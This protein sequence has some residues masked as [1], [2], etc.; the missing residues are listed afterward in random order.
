MSAIE[1]HQSPAVVG[2]TEWSL[3]TRQAE[4]LANSDIIPKAYYRKPA[5]VIVAAITGRKY[6]WDVLT[7]MRNGHVIEGTW[8][9]KPEA[10]LGLVRQAGHSV[11]ADIGPEGATVH[12]KRGDTGD[13]M[14]VEF[15]LAD[16]TRAGLAG[17]GSWRTYPQA[18]CM[19]RATA[20]LC[21]MLFSD[22]TA[23]SLSVEEMGATIDADG[24]IVD[25]E[26]LEP[27]SAD[28]QA[29][30]RTA[31]DDAGIAVAA[32]LDKAGFAGKT[33]DEMHEQDRDALPCAFKALRADKDAAAGT[34]TA[35]PGT[36]GESHLPGGALNEGDES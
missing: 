14:T 1:L 5:N 32:V 31:C 6:G 8:S 4:T 20:F 33:L 9:M 24:E 15:T 22:V 26:I 25:A 18:M 19:W 23:G 3:I 2:A 30:I 17:K 34:I 7:A 35:P 12:G 21:R 27:L 10:M 11:I 28:R 13:E 29:A 36:A 16:A